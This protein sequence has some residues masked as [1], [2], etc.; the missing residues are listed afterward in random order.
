MQNEGACHTCRGRPQLL[1]VYDRSPGR[2]VAKK[3]RS[4]ADACIYRRGVTVREI[5]ELHLK[6]LGARIHPGAG[7]VPTTALS[8][9]LRE[10]DRE[11]RDERRTKI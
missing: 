10:E 3:I 7:A 6:L 2:S 4:V 8:P 1:E 9:T 5:P 11:E